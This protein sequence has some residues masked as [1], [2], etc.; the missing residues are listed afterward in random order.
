MGHENPGGASGEIN[1]KYRKIDG[2]DMEIPDPF[3]LVIFGASRDLRQR[4]TPHCLL[5]PFALR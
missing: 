3:S 2:C 4:G 1:G 5:I